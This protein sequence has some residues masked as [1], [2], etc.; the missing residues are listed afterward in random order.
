MHVGEV[1]AGIIG[2]RIVRYDIYGSD[3]AIANRM[4]SSGAVG[5]VNVSGTAKALLEASQVLGFKFNTT[6]EVLNRRCEA[7]FI[8]ERGLYSV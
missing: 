1:V 3:V 5:R 7:Y 2:S 6:V 4:E 8:S